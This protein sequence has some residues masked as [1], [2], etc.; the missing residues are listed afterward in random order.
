M[1]PPPIPAGEIKKRITADIVVI[2]AGTS[3]LVC[4][5]AAVENGAKVV[6]IASSSTPVGRGGS[7]HAF[8]TRLMRKLGLK[9]DLAKEFKDE[10]KCHPLKIDQ[11]KWWLW[12]HK[13]GEAMDWLMDKMEAAGYQSVIELGNATTQILRRK[14]RVLGCEIANLRR[15]Q[16]DILKLL[17][18]KQLQ[19]RVEMINKER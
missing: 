14:L 18:Q 12:A 3:G 19:Q 15:Q 17:K 6:V 16:H 5:N 10:M 4:A 8:N 7:N 1:P 2:G 9:S 13:S 11:H